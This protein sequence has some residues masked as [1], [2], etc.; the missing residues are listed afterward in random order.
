LSYQGSKLAKLI[1]FERETGIEAQIGFRKN[2][3]NDY[4]HCFCSQAGTSEKVRNVCR[5]RVSVFSRI[6]VGV[7]RKWQAIHVSSES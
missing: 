7:T 4:L 5:S 2:A 6:P 3:K 1:F